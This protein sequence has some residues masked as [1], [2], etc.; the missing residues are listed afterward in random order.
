M[1]PVVSL[2][3]RNT[4][5]VIVD[6]NIAARYEAAKSFDLEDDLAYCPVLTI[7]EVHPTPSP[8][9]NCFI[10]TILTCVAGT[11][12]LRRCNCKINIFPW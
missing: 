5:T 7:D 2:L 11:S 9:H 12:I 8:A 3:T 10:N 4:L 6:S 1:A